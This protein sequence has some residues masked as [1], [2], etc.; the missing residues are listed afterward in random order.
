MV[1]TFLL[2]ALAAAAGCSFG[3][4]RPLVGGDGGPDGNTDGMMDG[5]PVDKDHLLISE[6]KSTGT[7]EFIEIWNPTNRTIGLSN[8]YLSDV[9]DY[10]RLPANPSVAPMVNDFVVRFPSGAALAPK[11]VVTIATAG[12]ILP[13]A[14][15]AIDATSGGQ[16]M[17]DRKVN[18]TPQITNGGEVVILFYWDGMSDLVKDVDIVIAGM[19]TTGGNG[20]VVKSP[21]DGPDPD[22]MTTAYKPENGLLG[23]G[24]TAETTGTT[25]SYKRRKLETGNETQANTGNGITGDDETSEALK[26]TWDGDATNPLSNPTFGV[27]PVI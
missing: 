8:Y 22:T 5:P 26:A 17:A 7:D 14:T 3:D 12:G 18:G 11:Q 25:T 10:W 16:V 6:I 13:A 20:L 23:N 27:A 2:C 1:R 4:D 9:G 19:T 15:F 21:V 24:M